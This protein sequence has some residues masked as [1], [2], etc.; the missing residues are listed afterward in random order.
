MSREVSNALIAVVVSYLLGS[1]N[2]AVIFSKMFLKKDVRELGSGNAGTTNVLRTAGFL[3]GLLTFVFDALKGFLA[4]YLGN[5]IFDAMDKIDSPDFGIVGAY[6]CGLACMIGHVLPIFF[7]F[8][9]GKGVATSVGIYAV[10]C[11]IAI[12]AGLIAFTVSLIAFK[13]V[14]LSSLI[15]TVFVVAFAFIFHSPEIPMLLPMIFNVIM[16]VIVYVKHIDNIKRLL[17]G[18]EKKITVGGKK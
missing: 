9:G 8:K 3:P 11:P 12:I 18:E 13:R 16:G 6:L 7:R 10:C 5:Y 2:F 15:A 17:R 4:A 14:S 1:I